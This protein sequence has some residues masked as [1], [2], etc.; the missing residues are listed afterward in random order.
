M[1]T[2]IS[3]S[4]SIPR[5]LDGASV[6]PGPGDALDRGKTI[7]IYLLNGAPA[8]TL[9]AKL[10]SWTGKVVRLPRSR[11]ADVIKRDEVH[12]IGVHFHVGADQSI[13]LI[14]S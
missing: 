9:T 4:H 1:M 5:S 11:L 3:G 7:R 8:G 10:M 12:R 14:K 6:P 13:P 2:S